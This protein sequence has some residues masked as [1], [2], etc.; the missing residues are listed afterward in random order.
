M[1]VNVIGENMSQN[2]I[3]AYVDYGNKKYSGR[4]ITELIIKAD[5]EYAELEFRFAD[6]PFDRIRRITGYLVGTTERFNNAKRQEES[7]RIKHTV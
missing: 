1:T 5:G 7:D 2:E 3:D 6:V 4:E